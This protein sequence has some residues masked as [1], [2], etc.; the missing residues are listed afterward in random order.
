MGL[1][2]MKKNKL[3]ATF[4]HFNIAKTAMAPELDA[5]VVVQAKMY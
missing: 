2:I 1:S 5:Q 3:D 4:G